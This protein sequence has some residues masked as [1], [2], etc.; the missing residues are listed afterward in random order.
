MVTEF[1]VA[2][3]ALVGRDLEVRPDGEHGGGLGFAGVIIP[4]GL[5]Q[6]CYL[7][8]NSASPN[9]VRSELAVTKI[10]YGAYVAATILRATPVNSGSVTVLASADP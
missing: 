1:E 6:R 5:A 9:S 8:S 2:G 4:F 7:F 10:S 3:H